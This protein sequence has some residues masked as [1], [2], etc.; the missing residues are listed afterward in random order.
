MAELNHRDK[1]IKEVIGVIFE[2]VHLHHLNRD[3]VAATTLLTKGGLNLDSIDILEIV[4][5]IE[6]HFKVKV[7]NAEIGKQ[8]FQSIGSITDFIMTAPR[9]GS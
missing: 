5:A 8:I 6:H 1:L 7:I 9:I 3:N 2:A 4:V